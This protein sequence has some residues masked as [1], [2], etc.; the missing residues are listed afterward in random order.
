MWDPQVESYSRNHTLVRYDVRGHGKSTG[1]RSNSSDGGRI[2]CE[3]A[4]GL[5]DRVSGLILVAGNPH[6]LDPT[7]E[8]EARFM[9]TDADRERRLLEIAHAGRKPEA[10]ELILDIWAPRVP[11]PE[12]ERLR[13]IASDNYE[14]MVDALGRD[15]PEGRRPAYPVAAS[16]RKGNIPLLSISG[17][18][19]NPALNMMMGR[20]A[21]E[22]PS[23]RHYELADGD[24]TPS[25]S[26]RPEFDS[27][28][29]GFLTRVEGGQSWPPPEN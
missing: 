25:L 23:A 4:A 19:D 20:F 17:A 11:L 16:L 12:R 2:A 29:L 22:V 9:D 3:F 21:Q 13:S 8:E 10:I 7:Q 5:P 1:D 14:R 27:L 6:D 15:V 28:V 26:A 18:H 24:H